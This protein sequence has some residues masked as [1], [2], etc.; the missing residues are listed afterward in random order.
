MLLRTYLLYLCI[1]SFKLGTILH[2]VSDFDN[3]LVCSTMWSILNF[4]VSG[5]LE[6]L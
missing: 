3:A 2:C 4:L 5:V 6:L 1:F